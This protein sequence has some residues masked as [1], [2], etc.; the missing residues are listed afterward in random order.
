MLCLRH[1]YQ[2][3][4]ETVVAQYVENRSQQHLCGEMLLKHRSPVDPSLLTRWRKRIGERSVAWLL[5]KTIEAGRA[6]GVISERSGEAVT[7]AY[8]VGVD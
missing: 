2:L 8:C 3:S 1:A 5:T 7:K 4:D 6:A